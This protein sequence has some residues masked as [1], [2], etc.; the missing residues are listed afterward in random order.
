MGAYLATQ[1]AE[2]KDPREA[3]VTAVANA[4][5]EYGHQD[6]HRHRHKQGERKRSGTSISG[7][8]CSGL[9][10]ADIIKVC[11]CLA[12]R[13]GFLSMVGS[14]FSPRVGPPSLAIMS[15]LPM[16]LACWAS[17]D[18]DASETHLFDHAPT[19]ACRTLP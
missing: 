15:D 14:M 3:Y 10:L 13:S 17:L 7:A 2:G 8:G 16:A 4:S 1:R 11:P 19:V 12:V 6:G 9:V 5:A 18:L